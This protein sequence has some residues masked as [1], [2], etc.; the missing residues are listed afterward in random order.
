[1]VEIYSLSRI[2]VG[3]AVMTIAAAADWKTRKVS[4][5]AWIFMGCVGM[6]ILLAQMFEA[7][8]YGNASYLIFVVIG[9]LFFDVFWDR[10]SVLGEK[11]LNLA[12]IALHLVALACVILF[13]MEEG[14]TTQ[15]LQ[16]ISI[17]IMILIAILFFYTGLLHGGADAKALMAL[18]IIFPFYIQ[19][20]GLPLIAYPEQTVESVQLIFPFA[21]LILMNAAILQ[22]VTVPLGLFFKN[23]ARRDFGFPEMFLGYRM[24]VEKVPKKFVWPME[25]VR[26]DEIVLLIF[27][28][29]DGSVKKELEMLKERGVEDIWVTPKVPF[30]IPMLLGL[31][32]SIVVGNI[33]LLFI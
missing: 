22:V 21:F 12:P 17:P 14:F 2:V 16:L 13:F 24:G 26:D 33:I 30:I 28:K 31:V 3:I 29:R 25:V 20:E 32:F 19:L 10:E 4:N 11:G 15:S 7:G 9:I 6:A 8:T 27:P 1:M 18:A 5:A 23:L